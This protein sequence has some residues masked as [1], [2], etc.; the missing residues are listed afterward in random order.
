MY[1]N[2]YFQVKMRWLYIVKQKETMIKEY[3]DKKCDSCEFKVEFL[4]KMF[5]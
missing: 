2:Y 5:N 3:F 4:N 1:A